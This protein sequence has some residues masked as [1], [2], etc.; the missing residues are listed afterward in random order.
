MYCSVTPLY[1]AGEPLSAEQRAAATVAG[2][3]EY[4]A[5]IKHAQIRLS[6]FTAYLVAGEDRH[7][8]L[9]P[10]DSAVLLRIDSRGMVL[11]GQEIIARGAGRNAR[12]ECHKQAWL[13]QPQGEPANVQCVRTSDRA[14]PSR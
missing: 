13:V 3:L 5:R 8:K 10:L 12:K 9:P 14:I 11:A 1:R 2:V 7:Y 4:E 6:V